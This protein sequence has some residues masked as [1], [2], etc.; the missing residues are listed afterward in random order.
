MSNREWRN[1]TEMREMI[2][3][4]LYLSR[5]PMTVDEVAELPYLQNISIEWV[6]RALHW[7]EM[8]E[9]VYVKPPKNKGDDYRYKT[10]KRIAQTKLKGFELV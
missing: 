9:W 8:N 3:A 7:L 2:A 10:Y 6:D 1:L 5:H 4:S